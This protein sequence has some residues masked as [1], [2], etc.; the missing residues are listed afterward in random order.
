MIVREGMI[1]VGLGVLLGI[2]RIWVGARYVQKELFQMKPIEPMSVLLSLGIL[3]GAALTA[4]LIPAVRA[5][6]LQP[7]ETLRQD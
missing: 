6:L 3:L 4:V 1:L 5:S 2:P 7:A